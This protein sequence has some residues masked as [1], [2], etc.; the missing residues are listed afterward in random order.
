M[1]RKTSSSPFSSAAALID[2]SEEERSIYAIPA[3]C[4]V[5][6]SFLICRNSSGQGTVDLRL[7][8]QL[9]NVAFLVLHFLY[10]RKIFVLT[11]K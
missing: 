6:F 10:H 1:S 9:K 2:S 5:S 4:H 11:V 3:L 7:K 8:A